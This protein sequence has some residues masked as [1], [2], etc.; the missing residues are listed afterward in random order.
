MK[1]LMSLD[2]FASMIRL[3]IRIVYEIVTEV[4]Y[5]FRGFFMNRDKD[6]QVYIAI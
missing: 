5:L 4:C 6:K 2:T 3:Y 1:E